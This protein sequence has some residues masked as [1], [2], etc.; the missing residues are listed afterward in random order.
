MG[1]DAA[2]HDRRARERFIRAKQGKRF[3]SNAMGKRKSAKSGKVKPSVAPENSM[4]IVGGR[5]RGRKFQY[6]GDPQTRPM[7]DRVREA[8]FNLLGPEVKGKHA[9]DL[10]AGT[11]A[12]GLEAISRGAVSGTFI[13][14]HFPT[15][16]LI[17]RNV[18]QL[19]CA[20]ACQVVAADTFLWMRENVTHLPSLPWAVFCSPP[21]DL[22][23]D[24]EADLL[25]MMHTV[26]DAAPSGS[27]FIV[28]SDKRFEIC[29]QMP[30]TTW[31]VRTYPPAVV[32]IARN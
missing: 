9:L 24:R 23:C 1:S 15:A 22:F 10:F 6:H 11:G 16:R 26:F 19:G 12:I 31:D 28:E 13:E 7:K 18:S 27:A 29:K 17:E 8:I 14:R 21:Y 4:R 2:A 3:T 5:L 32:A 20:E 25:Q 30:F